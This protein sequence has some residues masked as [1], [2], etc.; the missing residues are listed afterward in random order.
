MLNIYLETESKQSTLRDAQDKVLLQP[1][2]ILL[3]MTILYIDDISALES[4]PSRH[5]PGGGTHDTCTSK[6]EKP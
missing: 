4:K 2:T 6:V 3:A 5:G 1:S